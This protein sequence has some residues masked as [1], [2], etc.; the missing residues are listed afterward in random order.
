M[1]EVA[2]AAAALEVVTIAGIVDMIMIMRY[3]FNLT[4]LCLP[5]KDAGHSRVQS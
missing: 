3:F 5:Q 1:V 2:A 4:D